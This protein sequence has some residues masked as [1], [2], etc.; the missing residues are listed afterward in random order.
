MVGIFLEGDCWNDQN[1]PEGSTN[2]SVS[3][4]EKEP[5]QN[6]NKEWEPNILFVSYRGCTTHETTRTSMNAGN[7]VNKATFTGY[8]IESETHSTNLN[9]LWHVTCPSKVPGTKNV[10]L[11]NPV[12][13]CQD[14]TCTI[15]HLSMP[16]ALLA[17]IK[18][19]R[20]NQTVQSPH[21]LKW[22]LLLP[23]YKLEFSY[24]LFLK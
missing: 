3:E 19:C 5:N 22:S 17:E 16:N 21:L 1:A 23:K 15:L 10:T 9:Q 20:S 13:T 12:N 2:V 11:D 14:S 18:Y 24:N 6:N 7:K 4:N 8:C